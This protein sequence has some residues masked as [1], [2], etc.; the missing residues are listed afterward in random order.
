[1][2]QP[3]N[4]KEQKPP[5]PRKIRVLDIEDDALKTIEATVAE[6]EAI[7]TLLD[8]VALQS[9]R[10]DYRLRRTGGGRVQLSGRLTAHATQ[11]CVVSLE[12]LEARIE[13]PVEMELWPEALVADFERKARD[14]SQAG[15]IDEWP[16]AIVEGMIDLGP[17][18]Y[19]TL[20][21]T[22]EPYPKKE[23]ARL[24]WSQDGDAVDGPK[25]GP[26]ASLEQLKRP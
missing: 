6:R 26:F 4:P 10:F 24:Q 14:P 18:V 11:T 23:G 7:K 22:L 15:L 19:E 16:E 5:M 2:T 20:A 1:M 9:L 13:I 25:T 3:V 8:L 21:M 12:P 17:I